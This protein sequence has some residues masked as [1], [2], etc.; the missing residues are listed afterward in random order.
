MQVKRFTFNPFGEST[1]IVWDSVS[2][3]AVVVDPGMSTP[4][5]QAQFDRFVTD[6]KLNVRQI[7][8][9][10]MHLDHCWGDN[11]VRD[12]YGVKVAANIDDDFLGSR[13]AEQAAMFGMPGDAFKPVAIDVSLVD[14]DSIAVGDSN[15][16]VLQVPGH[17]PGSIALYSPSDDFVIVGDALFRGAIGRTDLPGGSYNTLADSIHTKLFTLP[18]STIVYPGHEETTTIGREK[19]SNPY[20]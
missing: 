10:H 18:D 14:G 6:N 8:N 12:R 7:I 20:V 5:E 11:Y 2:R 9:T 17:S 15:L 4:A 1:Y 16:Y 3:D 19:A 13:A